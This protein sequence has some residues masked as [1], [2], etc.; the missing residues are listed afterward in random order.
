MADK[1]PAPD[2]PTSRSEII[3][4][5]QEWVDAEVADATWRI[6]DDPAK[7]NWLRTRVKDTKEE[8][9]LALDRATHHIVQ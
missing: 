6:G 5:A 3:T 8:F 4:A 9:F 1:I 7:I 2:W